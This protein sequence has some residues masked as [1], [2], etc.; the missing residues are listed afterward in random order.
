MKLRKNLD[1][2]QTLEYPEHLEDIPKV[3]VA[4]LSGQISG[5]LKVITPN[6][7]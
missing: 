6:H 4:A 3:L 1:K 5:Q 2:P 7:L